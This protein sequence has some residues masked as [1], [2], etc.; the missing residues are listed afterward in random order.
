[1]VVVGPRF[2]STILELTWQACMWVILL[3][4]KVLLKS[5]GCM[6]T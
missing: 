2:L 3:M 4:G 5:A 1:M 6:L